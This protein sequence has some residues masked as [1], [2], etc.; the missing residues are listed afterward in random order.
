MT[1]KRKNQ[2]VS[3]EKL[4]FALCIIS[5]IAMFYTLALFLFIGM[6]PTFV[7][8]LT[9]SKTL[10]VKALTVGMMNFSGCFPFFMEL[11]HYKNDLAKSLDVLSDPMTIVTAYIAASIGY[12]IDWA[13]SGIASSLLFQ[14]GLDRQ[15]A[16]RKEQEELI[17]RWGE[18]VNGETDLDTDGF[19][20]Y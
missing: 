12:L 19:P 20:Y 11:V 2:K 15:K 8:Y 3:L 4:I 6:L 18:Y 1:K 17:E 14:R 16:I 9:S 10:K 5:L 7:A 13:V